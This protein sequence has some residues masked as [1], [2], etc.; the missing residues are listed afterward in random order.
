MK[1]GWRQNNVLGFKYI[2]TSVRKCKERNP[3]ESQMRSFLKV[4]ML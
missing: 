1:M 2:P 3:K 4:A